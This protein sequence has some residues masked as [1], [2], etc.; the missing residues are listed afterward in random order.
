MAFDPRDGRLWVSDVGHDTE[1]EVTIAAMGANLGWP[2][3]E[4]NSCLESQR[5]YQPAIT[6]LTL[7]VYGCNEIEGLTAPII[8]L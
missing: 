6:V 7:S 5:V 2:I 1:E 4:G 3:F 8:Y